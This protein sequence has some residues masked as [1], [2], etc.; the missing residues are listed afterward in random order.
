MAY[1][2]PLRLEG[3]LAKEEST[4]G[5]DPTPVAG[6]DGVRAVQRLWVAPTPEWAFPNMNED[7]VSNSLIQAKPGQPR[8]R[9]MDVDLTVRAIGAGAAYSS[10]TPVRP[11][12][13]PLLRSAALSRVH[14]DTGGSETVTYA[15]ADSGHSSCTLYFYAGGKLFKVRGFRS[16]LTWNPLAGELGTFRFRGQGLLD[17][18]TEVAV[19][20]ITYD[21]V[22]QPAAVGMGLAIVPNGFSSWGPHAVGME[23]TTGYEIDRFDDPNAADGIEGFFIGETGPRFSFEPRVED[24]SDYAGY[25]HAATRVDHT[26]DFTL[27]STQ[28]NRLSLAVTLA[29]LTSDP[30][31]SESGRFAAWRAEYLCRDGS[32]IFD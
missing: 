15:F 27:G 17:A 31:P 30:T 24:L 25:A 9:M 7:L 16:N 32:I 1:P 2:Y 13:D 26:I 21:S 22:D 11:E 6:T 10:V 19:P 12:S 3:L 20:S 5:T 18:P 29:H 14:V 8:G 4:Y 23:F 28:Y